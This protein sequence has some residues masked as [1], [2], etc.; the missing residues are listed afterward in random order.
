MKLK[1]FFAAFIFSTG[2]II[3]GCSENSMMNMEEQTPISVYPSDNAYGVRL[4]ERIVLNF[5]KP[6]N[7]QIVENN[8]HLISEKD[9]A[10]SSCSFGNDMNHGD[11]S[12]AMM[13][14]AKM[15]HLMD[16][17]KTT[18]RFSWNSGSTECVFIP[19]SFMTPNMNYMI[20]FGS[21]MIGM[22]ND[23]MGN[24]MGGTMMNGMEG[25]GTGDMTGHMMLHFTTMDTTS[26]DGGHNE[27]H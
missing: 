1:I 27:H 11:M 5:A 18:G 3:T 16:E 19:D 22:M 25:M 23:M 10:D 24:M 17:H 13:D 8:F 9:M 12:M 4:D 20:H 6:V 15:N 14:S 21:E 7:R 2:I 26:G